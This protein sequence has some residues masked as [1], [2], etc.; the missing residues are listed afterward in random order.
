M[1]ILEHTDDFTKGIII[2]RFRDNGPHFG[3]DVSGEEVVI[4]NSTDPTL[5]RLS[6]PVVGSL[7]YT[8]VDTMKALVESGTHSWDEV[9]V[10]RGYA[11]WGA[12][13]L[14]KELKVR[15]GLEA[16]RQARNTNA[17]DEYGT[18]SYLGKKTQQLP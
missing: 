15:G 12:G 3:G 2:N 13:Q 4:H 5:I 10:F 18:R 11:G 6:L 7:H 9:Y 1:L 14:D 8:P 17:S 16:K